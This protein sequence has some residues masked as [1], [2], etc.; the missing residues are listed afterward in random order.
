MKILYIT[1]GSVFLAIGILGIVLP[2]LPTTPFLLLTAFFYAKGSPSFHR[3]FIQTKI[4]DKYLSDFVERKA[5]K[6]KEKWQLMIFVD[7]VLILT[8]ILLNNIIVTSILLV[9]DILKY[10]YFFTLVKTL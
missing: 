5:M 4:Y 9:I 7:I 8:I 2:V 6:R 3:W 1:L 10:L